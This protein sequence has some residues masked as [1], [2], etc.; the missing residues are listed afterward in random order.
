MTAPGLSSL[1]GRL[2]QR[3][4]RRTWRSMLMVLLVALLATLLTVSHG[5][6]VL[7]AELSLADLWLL[8]RLGIL[9]LVLLIAIAGI[10]SLVSQFAFWEGWLQGLPQPAEFFAQAGEQAR[11]AAAAGTGDNPSPCRRYVVYLDGIHQ[12]ERNHPPRITEFLDELE[13]AL[14]GDTRLLR[15]LDGYTV[16]PGALV[17]EAGS[18]WFWR[19]VFALQE[20]HSHWLVQLVCAVLVQGNNVIKVGISSDRRY[21]PIL[22]YE[23]ALKISLRLTEMGYHPGIEVVLFGYS[24]GGEMALGVADY[25]RRLCRAP[26]RI[27]TCCGVFSGNQV[28][29]GVEH[30]HTLVGSR[31]PVAAFGQLAYPGRSPLLPLSNWNRA[32]RQGLVERVAVL[33][34]THNGSRGPFAPAFRSQVIGKVLT[35]MARSTAERAEKDLNLVGKTSASASPR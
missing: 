22:N 16:M 30:I 24:G 23:L 10:Y 32:Q 29:E 31:D 33:G 25:L 18:T 12:V 21:G 34:M 5:S 7:W 8:L 1:A 17:E 13:Q 14:P 4:L 35:L 28:V 6:A 2:Q 27:V 20:H 11:V 9:V 26:V 15:G 19:R 3:H